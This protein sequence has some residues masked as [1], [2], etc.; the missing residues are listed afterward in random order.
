LDLLN[1]NGT[2]KVDTGSYLLSVF[3]IWESLIK[4]YRY[5]GATLISVSGLKYFTLVGTNFIESAN[6]RII[7]DR[8]NVRTLV[9]NLRWDAGVLI[10][11]IQF[12]PGVA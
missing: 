3:F 4:I 10:P 11:I 1:N 6:R 8:S 12:L 5:R 9:A 7:G 2:G